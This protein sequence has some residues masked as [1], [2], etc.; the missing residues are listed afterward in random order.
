I[1]PWFLNGDYSRESGRES[2]YYIILLDRVKELRESDATQLKIILMRV[3]EDLRELNSKE[4]SGGKSPL[5]RE[6]NRGR[7]KEDRDRP[8]VGDKLKDG[9]FYDDWK[10]SGLDLKDFAKARGEPFREAE[11]RTARERTRR[12]RL[13]KKRW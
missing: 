2:I 4:H 7:R 11:K 3:E 9:K 12:N 13:G 5:G 1:C 10:S 8:P 6:Q